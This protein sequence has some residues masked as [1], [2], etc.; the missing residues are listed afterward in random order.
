[1]I[2]CLGWGSL[3]WD[4]R[5][6]PLVDPR[7]E[8]WQADGPEL[9][10]EFARVSGGG[11]LTLV[12]D[13]HAP[14]IRVLWSEMSVTSLEGA[15]AALRKREGTKTSWIGRW[16]N[17]VGIDCID[18]IDEWARSRKFEGVVWSA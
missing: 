18:A 2:V 16:S 14:A 4:P 3:I 13:E 11:R 8:L 10:I 1:M 15:V 5:D 12:I 7:P 17:G 6:L 9:P